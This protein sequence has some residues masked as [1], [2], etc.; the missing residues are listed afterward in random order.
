LLLVPALRR[1]GPALYAPLVAGDDRVGVLV[2]LRRIGER[3]FTDADL[4]TAQTFAGQAA[5]ALQLADGRRRT[6]EADLLEDRARISRDLHDLVVQELFAMGMRLNRLRRGTDPAVVADIDSSLESLDRA[7]RQIR[8][9]IRALRDPADVT[10]LADRL[11][12]EANRAHISLGFHPRL[13]LHPVI[14]LDELVPVEVADDVVAV[15][16]EGLSNA[17]RH[18]HA[19]SVTVEV[20]AN[21]ETITVTVVDDGVGL[22]PSFERR[23]G[24]DNLAERARRHDGSSSFRLN[25][26]GGTTLTW[27]ARLCT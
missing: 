5:L 17:A 3:E 7:V 26:T 2:L 10:G 27:Q 19:S 21:D 9:T 23:S 15:V 6:E 8:A 20:E 4:T 24:V 18:A 1:Y 12:G 14:G 16:R 13:T 11:T 22:P 25:P